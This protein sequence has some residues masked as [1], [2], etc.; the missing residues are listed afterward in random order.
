MEQQQQQQQQQQPIPQQQQRQH[1]GEFDKGQFFEY[2]QPPQQQQ[3]PLQQPQQQQQQPQQQQQQQPAAM[4]VPFAPELAFAN[5]RDWTE[6]VDSTTI[7]DLMKQ[8][9]HPRVQA[10]D[11]FLVITS[12]LPIENVLQ[13]L[14]EH[15]LISLPVVNESNQF[16]GFVD[17]L[18]ILSY[19]LAVWNQ[20]SGGR[21]WERAAFPTDEF[22]RAPIRNV[23]NFSGV[24][25]AVGIG[26]EQMVREGIQSLAYPS[27]RQRLHRLAVF[28]RDRQRIVNVASLSDFVSFLYQNKGLLQLNLMLAPVSTLGIYRPV[29]SVPYNTR[30]IDALEILARN[31][32][33][34][35][36]ITDENYRLI[37]NFSASDLRGVSARTAEFFDYSIADVLSIVPGRKFS[38]RPKPETP[39]VSASTFNN[40]PTTSSSSPSYSASSTSS[41]AEL[42]LRNSG[43]SSTVHCRLATPFS[44]VLEKLVTNHIHRLY[45]VDSLDRPIGVITLGDILPLVNFYGPISPRIASPFTLSENVDQQQQQQLQQDNSKSLSVITGNQQPSMSV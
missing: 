38:S 33:S 34:G 23:I 12:V 39:P 21:P 11:T 16:I 3:Q 4:S 43:L 26:E 6:L 32:I 20:R 31:R 14:Q 37:G 7:A 24:D 30:F 17:V 40:P 25:A 42:S 9:S 45:V 1:Q 10:P 13:T 41:D 5:P 35:L 15:D 22:F 44:Q 18:D 8:K 27:L 36:A 19:L 28:S 29:I 2:Q